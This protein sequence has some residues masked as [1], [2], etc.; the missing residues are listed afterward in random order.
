VLVAGIVLIFVLA[1]IALLA[2]AVSRRSSA[3]RLSRETRSR[4][5]AAGHT[6][7]TDLEA[8]ASAEGRARSEESQQ[9]AAAGV[10]A[11]RGETAVAEWEP[12]DEEELGVSRRQFLNRANIT[13]IGLG[14]LP[15]FGVS[16]IAFLYP[17]KAGGFGVPITIGKVSEIIDFIKNN[18]KPFYAA[19]ARTY[20]QLYP[21]DD[22]TLKAAN[23]AYEGNEVLMGLDQGVVALWQRCVH[24]GC[25]VPWCQSSQWFECPCHGSKYN[26]VG[27]KKDGPAP[28]GLDR[29][30]VDLSGGNFTVLTGTVFQGPPL[31][32]DTTGQKPEGPACV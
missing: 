18:K 4:D 24:L 9:T 2:T 30:A 16:L 1:A 23:K 10:P 21:S 25:R 3:G 31:G 14:S 12:V 5:K 22:A 19:Q 8:A 29:F 11:M 7:G 13:M 32:T 20:V 26:K 6:P 28:R 27:E 15:L 17:G